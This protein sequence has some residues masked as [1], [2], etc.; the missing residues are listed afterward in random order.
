MYACVRETGRGF[1][2]WVRT[3]SNAAAQLHDP[4]P[5]SLKRRLLLPCSTFSGQV[6]ARNTIT[7]AIEIVRVARVL[8]QHLLCFFM[9]R[10]A[11]AVRAAISLPRLDTTTP[12]SAS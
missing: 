9:G 11:G 6:F 12:A 5:P 3:P 7:V 2:A 1:F 10:E 8:L 4:P